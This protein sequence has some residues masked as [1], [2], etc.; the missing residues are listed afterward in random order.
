MAETERLLND[1]ERAVLEQVAE[2]D[3]VDAQRAAALLAVDSGETQATAAKLSGLTTG[4]VSYALRKFRSQ[5]L[6]AFPDALAQVEAPP[7]PA[8]P[9]A[10]EAAAPPQQEEPETAASEAEAADKR[11]SRRITRLLKEMDELVEELRTTLPAAGQSPYSPLRMLLLV[12]DNLSRYT[13]E[14]QLRILEQFEGM[15]RE[16]LMDL[17][18]WK[19]I[20]FMISYSA[21]FQANQARERLNQQMP[22]PLKPDTILRA[23]KGGLDRIT[24]DIAKDMASNLEGAAR[25]DLMDPD[26]W[27]GMA[28]LIGYSAQ[29]QATQAKDR[30]NEQMPDPLKPDT[31]FRLFKESLDKVT[32]DVA[33]Q[34]VASFEGATKEDL[35]DP[36]TWKGVWYMLNY[37]LHFQ[38]EQM[39]MRLRGQDAAAQA[40]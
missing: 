36:D 34:I 38:A 15:T 4:Q 18:T 32:P 20:A 2:Q 9:A 7:T 24:P 16:D 25:E 11:R 10:A 27:K 6:L 31:I 33:K 5:R 19:G 37:S 14:V 40:E 39:K 23:V 29:L 13:P 26:T 30:L 12:R 3:N 22:N 1:E 8:E 35:L 21:Q 17:D 28:Y